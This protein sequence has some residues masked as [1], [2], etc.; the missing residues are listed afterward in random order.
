M[1]ILDILYV[2][3]LDILAEPETIMLQGCIMIDIKSKYVSIYRAW[4]DATF[5]GQ[6]IRQ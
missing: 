2:G 5:I 3:T 6:W 1:D 4:Q